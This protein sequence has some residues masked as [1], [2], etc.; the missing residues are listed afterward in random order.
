M[1]RPIPFVSTSHIP[2]LMP[3]TSLDDAPLLLEAWQI[4]CWLR[5]ESEFP[6]TAQALDD[7]RWWADRCL[8][9]AQEIQECA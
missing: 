3:P 4:A 8:R 1:L 6:A 7:S 2:Y 9:L 5:W